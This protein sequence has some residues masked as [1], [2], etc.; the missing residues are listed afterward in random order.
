V[1]P[2]TKTSLWRALQSRNKK[3]ITLTLKHPAG[4][5]PAKRLIAE[6]D[7]LVENFRLRR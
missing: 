5:A 2:R 6:C 7:M 4:L 1:N 3:L